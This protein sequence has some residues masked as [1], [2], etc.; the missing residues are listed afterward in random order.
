MDTNIE[1]IVHLPS[2]RNIAGEMQVLVDGKAKKH[3]QVAGRGSAGD[4]QTW[5]TKGISGDKTK[6]GG[7][8]PTGKYA[9]PGIEST[10]K[11]DQ[12]A[13]GPNGKIR[14][15]PL[16]GNALIAKDV[17]SRNGL[18]IHGGDASSEGSWKQLGGLR[19]T[20]GCLRLS[21]DNMKELIS[22]I[23]ETELITGNASNISVI[24]I[25]PYVENYN[26]LTSTVPACYQLHN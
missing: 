8:T 6:P 20:H 21:N 13:Y 1:L 16:A 23:S 19:P 14:L 24:V 9:V 26:G 25:D 7:N 10:T 5:A 22:L 4:G 15:E 12:K 18:L 11:N 3:Y 17:F 2:N